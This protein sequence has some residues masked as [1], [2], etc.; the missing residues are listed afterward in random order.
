MSNLKVFYIYFVNNRKLMRPIKM[1]LAAFASL[2]ADK[3][4]LVP[5]FARSRRHPSMP[6]TGFENS[7]LTMTAFRKAL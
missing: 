2:R 4:C 5:R 7:A 1:Q 6:L 3:R